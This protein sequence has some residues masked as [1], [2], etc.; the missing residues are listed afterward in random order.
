MRLFI[1][2][3]VAGLTAG[4]HDFSFRKAP[5]S[6]DAGDLGEMGDLYGADLT[7]WD[8]TMPRDLAGADLTGVDMMPPEGDLADGGVIDGDVSDGMPTDLAGDLKM[9]N[10]CMNG[11]KDNGETDVDCGGPCAKCPDTKGCKTGADCQSGACFIAPMAPAGTCNPPLTRFKVDNF[12]DTTDLDFSKGGPDVKV[13]I[14]G[15]YDTMHDYPVLPG[16][17]LV[18]FVRK[19]GPNAY[20]MAKGVQGYVMW[21]NG[22]SHV[23]CDTINGFPGNYGFSMDPMKPCQGL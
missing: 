13:P 2:L 10:N 5:A 6:S 11:I 15:M 12:A 14:A 4:C 1:A 20:T 18:T 3:L 16:T 8:M 19:T 7:Q 21:P 17:T 9:P 22:Q 23:I